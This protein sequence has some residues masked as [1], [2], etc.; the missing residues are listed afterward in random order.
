MTQKPL[1]GPVEHCIGKGITG[2][3]FTAA[4]P[5]NSNTYDA[6]GF[7]FCDRIGFIRQRGAAMEKV[8]NDW[9]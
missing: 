2:V 7:G 4:A 6:R 9:S 1:V 5:S 8:R 3:R